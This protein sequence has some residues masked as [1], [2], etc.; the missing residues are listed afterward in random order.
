MKSTTKKTK[1]RF[2]YHYYKQYN[3]M[4]VHFK[5]TCH[6]VDDVVCKG[7]DTETKWNKTQPML[8][9]RGFANNI[10]IKDGVAIIE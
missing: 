2:F 8:V 6:T 4:S 3:K 10:T 9:I 1:F 7:V 5:K